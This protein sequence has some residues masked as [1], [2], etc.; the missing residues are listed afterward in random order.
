MP[1]GVISSIGPSE[2]RYQGPRRQDAGTGVGGRPADLSWR[3]KS[4]AIR[5]CSRS[6]R[7]P[8]SP[9]PAK[10]SWKRVIFGPHVGSPAE[11]FAHH[12]DDR[13]GCAP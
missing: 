7:R 10:Q 3:G 12:L 6:R 8:V 11:K 13:L 2:T 4:R 9:L 1:F 5:T